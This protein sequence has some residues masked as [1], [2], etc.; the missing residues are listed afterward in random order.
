MENLVCI[1]QGMLEGE[2]HN[3]YIVFKGIPY[4]K[5]PIGELRW[6]EPQAPEPWEGIR[7]ADRF[8]KIS[9]QEFPD[10]KHPITGRFKK[11]FYS[12][13]AYIPQ[14]SE[15]CLY[16]NVWMPKKKSEEGYPVAFWIHGGG[17]GGGYS[18][19]IEF[20]GAEYAHRG[21]I[22]VTI[23]YRLHIFG[24]LAHPW[25]SRE[26][27]ES[28]SGNYGILDQ[29]AALNWVRDN[30]SAFG[31]DPDKITVFGQSAGSMSTQVLVSSQLTKGKISRAI[32]QSGLACRENILATPDLSEAEQYGEIFVQCTGARNI[33]E[34]RN[35][36]TEDLMCA[37]T[38]FDKMMWESGK[39]IILVPN[40]DGY[41]LQKNVKQVWNS[42]EMHHI[43]YMLGVVTDDLGST[44]E[45]VK[46]KKPGVLLEECKRWAEKC[47][48]KNV[49]TS[50][51]YYFSHELPGDDWGAFHSSELWYTF[52]TCDRCWRPMTEFDL[53]LSEEML[54]FWTSFIKTGNPEARSGRSW[55]DYN[56]NNLYIKEFK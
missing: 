8:E 54:D 9:I 27:E 31:G 46:T 18:S 50:Y 11:E 45:E 42:G 36:S 55:P 23:E 52:G 12:D 47:F 4:A 22:L 15:D 1:K 28:R 3:E 29:I 56:K 35:M 32:L 38:K 2:A 20:D 17:F 48:E 25:L 51:L 49:G 41:V 53:K 19:E 21:V 7:K 24:F 39:G 14:M 13:P 5:A 40:V 6:R 43:P 34:L 44:E 26:N 33:D 30:I 37:R 16:L 10:D